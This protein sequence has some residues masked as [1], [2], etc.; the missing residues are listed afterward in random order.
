MIATGNDR[1]FIDTSMQKNQENQNNTR[2]LQHRAKVSNVVLGNI[3][4]SLPAAKKQF[5]L[6]NFQ[7][8]CKLL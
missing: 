6:I 8:L 2:K 5:L 1:P 3:F 7:Q 4:N